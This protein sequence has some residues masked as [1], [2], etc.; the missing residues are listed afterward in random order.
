MSFIR[1]IFINTYLLIG[2]AKGVRNVSVRVTVLP[3][4]THVN[5]PFP[6]DR[7]SD[8]PDV[9]QVSTVCWRHLGSISYTL[10]VVEIREFL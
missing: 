7:P 4:D 9:Y 5:T 10:T 8:T 3:L 6:Q 2:T 1:G